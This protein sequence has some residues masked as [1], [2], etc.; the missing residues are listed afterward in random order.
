MGRGKG[1][2][3]TQSELGKNLE[4]YYARRGVNAMSP[5]EE[6][7]VFMKLALVRWP[8]D[9]EAAAGSTG[10]NQSARQRLRLRHEGYR[11]I[12]DLRLQVEALAEAGEAALSA[13]GG[14][15]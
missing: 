1:R 2:Q 5:W 4:N 13:L 10:M 9:C 12:S 8:V 15:R 3:W 6:D 7:E 14:R 11:M